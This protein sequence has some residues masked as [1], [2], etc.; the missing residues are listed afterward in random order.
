K[1]SRRAGRRGTARG[2]RAPRGAL[3]GGADDI[4]VVFADPPLVRPQTL[5]RL[6]EPLG[7]GKAVAVLGFRPANP[8]GYGRL[9][10]DGETLSAIRE[11]KD[12]SAAERAIGLCN[13][14][15]VALAG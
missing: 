9:I 8:A 6:G 1:R 10:M 4:L 7:R 13:A 12:A 11:E 14:G 15:L 3:G 5:A 2:G